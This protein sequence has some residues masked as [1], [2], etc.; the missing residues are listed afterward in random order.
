[1]E[2]LLHRGDEPAKLKKMKMKRTNSIANIYQHA[3]AFTSSS[4]GRAHMHNSLLNLGA[5]PGADPV[6]IRA[7]SGESTAEMLPSPWQKTE[8]KFEGDC[9]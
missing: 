5:D 1:M 8:R 9:Q 7:P 2:E 6:I 3:A 4:V